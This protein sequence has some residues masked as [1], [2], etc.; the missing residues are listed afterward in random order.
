MNEPGLDRIHIDG[1]TVRCIIGVRDWERH[2]KQ[3]VNVHITLFADLRTAG[4]TDRMEDTIDYVEVKRQVMAL[5]EGSSFRLIERLAQ[6]IADTCLEA[7][8]VERVAVRLEKP[9]ALRHARTVGVEIV[10]D[11]KQMAQDG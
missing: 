8:R 3:S 7:P 10:R 2:E 5:I 1:L 4:R 9:G 11:R 6:R